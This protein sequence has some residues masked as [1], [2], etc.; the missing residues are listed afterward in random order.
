MAHIRG[1][2]FNFL[3]KLSIM[4]FIPLPSNAVLSDTESDCII[5]T[6]RDK[7][8]IEQDEAGGT[9]MWKKLSLYHKRSLVETFFS[10]YKRIFG[11]KLRIKK[12]PINEIT[13]K[14]SLLNRFICPRFV[15][16]M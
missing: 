8:L 7:A 9:N 12:K 14:I 15:A 13:I 4:A 6:A 5:L 1:S 3:A 16:K 10:R 2:I 11:P